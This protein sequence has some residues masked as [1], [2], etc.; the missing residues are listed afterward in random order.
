MAWTQTHGTYLM[1]ENM[2][3]MVLNSRRKTFSKVQELLD[4]AEDWIEAPRRAIYERPNPAELILARSAHAGGCTCR[5]FTKTLEAA[6]GRI[7]ELNKLGHDAFAAAVFDILVGKKL[8]R[9]CIYLWGTADGGKSTLLEPFEHILLD[10]QV[11]LCPSAQTEPRWFWNTMPGTK[12]AVWQEVSWGRVF[13]QAEISELKKFLGGE[14][15]QVEQKGRLVE[16]QEEE[17]RSWR[18]GPVVLVTPTTGG[19]FNMEHFPVVRPVTSDF[20]HY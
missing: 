9:R 1:Q 20:F 14:G 8:K 19:R 2:A 6:L 5:G 18:L 3:A 7:L 11:F 16:E 10:G 17:A 12:V 13:K 4:G 15:L